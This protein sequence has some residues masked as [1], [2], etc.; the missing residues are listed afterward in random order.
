METENSELLARRD[1]KEQM[2]RSGTPL[3]KFKQGDTSK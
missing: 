2:S 3:D 1:S